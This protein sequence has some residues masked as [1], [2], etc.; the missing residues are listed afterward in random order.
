MEVSSAAGKVVNMDKKQEFPVFAVL[1]LLLS[2]GIM[3]AFRT[4]YP[5][6]LQKVSEMPA[7]LGRG[8]IG[9]KQVRENMDRVNAFSLLVPALAVA[10]GLTGLAILLGPKMRRARAKRLWRKQGRCT[11]C[12]YDLTGLGPGHKC[13]ECFSS[14]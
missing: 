6:R 1:L 7:E 9:L 8:E 4:A 2:V 5:S 3:F 10:L 13:P 14:G 11:A 12:G